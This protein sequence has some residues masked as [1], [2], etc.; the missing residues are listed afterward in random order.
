MRTSLMRRMLRAARAAGRFA[1]EAT[2][3]AAHG[4]NGLARRPVFTRE[5]A[6]RRVAIVGG[7][8]AG[9]S[10]A[11]ALDDAGVPF[12]LF[13]AAERVGGRVFSDG[14]YFDEGQVFEWYGELIDT[15]H[16]CL[17]GLARRF[18]LA[19]DHLP[20]ADPPGARP[21][22]HFD[23]GLYPLRTAERDFMALWPALQADL[24]AAGTVDWRR[25][26]PAGRALDDMSVRDWIASKVAGGLRS[27]LG[28]LLDT[29]FW[30]ELN[31]DT[32][33]QSALNLVYLLGEQV[34]PEHF[35][36]YG[37]S[38]EVFKIQGGNGRLVERIAA[39]LGRDRLLCDT[40]LTAIA[41]RPDASV[42]L[43]VLCSGGAQ[44]HHF[45]RVILALPFAVLR[46]LDIAR[47]GFDA[48]KVQAIRELGRG[49][50]SKQHLQ[51]RERVWH[52]PGPDGLPGN[53]IS[54]ADT[55][56]QVTWEASRCQPGRGGILVGYCGGPYADAMESSRA[57]AFDDDPAVAA[58]ARRFIARAERVFPG[59]S[60][61]FNG[62][63]AHALPHLDP[64]FGC[65]Y[66][67]YRVG[68]YQR[69]SGYEAA[70]QGSV[71]FAGEHTSVQ[72]QGFMEGA[73]R[74]GIRAAEE[75]I[76][77]TALAPRRREAA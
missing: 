43:T 35:G 2:P 8:L 42:E 26:T 20:D 9:L 73:V 54:V 7:G 40:R 21:T 52:R 13:E 47:A 24:R 56:Y 62:R 74:E 72:Y 6:G 5:L 10:A 3:P 77:A 18:G 75:V 63:A 41:T 67:Y 65:S 4:S 17:L 22:F 71:H 70:A 34:D 57:F 15:Q 50:Q 39:H 31:A 14:G 27:P 66:S 53:G 30:I 46:R 44:V 12:V 55:G 76:A 28:R 68:Q 69:F 49:R 59:L 32:R 38:D 19:V 37:T 33:E 60:A 25:S 51:F 23:G 45:D 29:A 48:R 11:L 58:D 36:L 64:N 16:T 61:T 1:P